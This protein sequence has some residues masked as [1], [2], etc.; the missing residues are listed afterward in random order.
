MNGDDTTSQED[1]TSLTGPLASSQEEATALEERASPLPSP[2]V[3]AWKDT[4]DELLDR[5]D[6]LTTLALGL[7]PTI[8]IIAGLFGSIIGDNVKGLGM[9]SAACV[10]LAALTISGCFTAYALLRV[11]GEA[12]GLQ[13]EP[14]SFVR[15]EALKVREKAW[16]VSASLW[17]LIAGVF[18]TLVLGIWTLS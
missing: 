13:P 9:V 3:A 7:L 2:A 5:S 17:L 14:E 8:A 10:T 11:H 1:V 6:K 12:L 18:G 16:V 15:A 4:H